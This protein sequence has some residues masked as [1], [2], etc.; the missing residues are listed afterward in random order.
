[1]GEEPIPDIIQLS[2]VGL[3]LEAHVDENIS[4]VINNEDPP[5]ISIGEGGKFFLYGRECE[6][7]HE[8]VAAFRKW[9]KA[10]TA[11]YSNRFEIE[12]RDKV[13]F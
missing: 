8:I 1:M 2:P 6:D 7:P 3:T 5:A 9:H 10:F 4:F 13:T 12:V 11:R